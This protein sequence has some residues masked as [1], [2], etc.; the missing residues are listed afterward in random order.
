M[1]IIGRFD[2]NVASDSLEFLFNANE[3]RD[4]ELRGRPKQRHVWAKDEID[5]LDWIN[6]IRYV[7]LGYYRVPTFTAGLDDRRYAGWDPITQTLKAGYVKR[8]G[9]IVENSDSDALN[10]QIDVQVTDTH[11]WVRPKYASQ[12]SEGMRIRRT[13]EGAPL[14]DFAQRFLAAWYDKQYLNTD[15]WGSYNRHV[16]MFLP[17]NMMNVVPLEGATWADGGREPRVF[18]EAAA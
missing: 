3:Q 18:G 7:W 14:P 11:F 10:P 13:V 15:K 4:Y 16:R 9:S 12:L 17:G 1:T 2:P 8:F 6:Y 5:T